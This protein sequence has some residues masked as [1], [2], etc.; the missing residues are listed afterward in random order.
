VSTQPPSERPSVRASGPLLAP[1][2]ASAAL[3]SR[4]DEPLDGAHY[5]IYEAHPAPW[6]IAA[7][8]VAF[9]IFAVTYLITNLM[10]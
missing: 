7:I 2:G 5:H 10:E 3:A 8:W 1:G 9:F 6:W 4:P